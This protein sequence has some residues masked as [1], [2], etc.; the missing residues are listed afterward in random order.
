[1]IILQLT[2]L[3]LVGRGVSTTDVLVK[4]S[5][6]GVRVAK[7]G[8]TMLGVML[9][10]SCPIIKPPM[11]DVVWKSSAAETVAAGLIGVTTE[12]MG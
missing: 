4:M 5:T 6:T 3:E 9:I 10:E 7:L 2:M 1:M 11:R 8:L 12:P